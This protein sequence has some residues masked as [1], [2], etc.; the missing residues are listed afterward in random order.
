MGKEIVNTCMVWLVTVLIGELYI[1]WIGFLLKEIFTY[2]QTIKL[3][4]SVSAFYSKV[5]EWV[6]VLFSLLF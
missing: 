5:P 1:L 4:M 3:N 2:L 6:F